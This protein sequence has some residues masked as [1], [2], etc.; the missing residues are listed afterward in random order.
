[1]KYRFSY[2]SCLT[3]FFFSYEFEY[4]VRSCV[5]KKIRIEDNDEKINRKQLKIHSQQFDKNIFTF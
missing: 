4:F 5:N 2:F 1:M 3:Y